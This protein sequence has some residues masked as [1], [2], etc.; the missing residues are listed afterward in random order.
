MR[1]MKN[2]LNLVWG[3]LLGTVGVSC[4]E[5]TPT[6]SE[7]LTSSL[8]IWTIWAI[9]MSAAMVKPGGLLRI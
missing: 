2:Y 9:R 1:D 6:K 8:S 7:N 5:A 4:T 3:G